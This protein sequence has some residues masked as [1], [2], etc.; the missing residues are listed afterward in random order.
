MEVEEYARIAAAEDDH[1]WY[2]NTRGVIADLLDP[3]LATGQTILG[4]PLAADQMIP[5]AYLTDQ[6]GA[7]Q[8]HG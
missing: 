6:R 2:R 3:W 1:W 8:R 7:Q 4:P 5:Q